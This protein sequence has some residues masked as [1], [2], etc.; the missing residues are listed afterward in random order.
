MLSMSRLCQSMT[1]CDPLE[2][3]YGIQQAMLESLAEIVRRRRIVF[4][5]G[6]IS[7]L[8][9]GFHHSPIHDSEEMNVQRRP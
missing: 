7:G 4:A 8:A 6:W 9:D 5:V 3:A 2:A 1:T